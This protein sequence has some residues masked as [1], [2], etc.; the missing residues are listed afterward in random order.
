MNFILS[1]LPKRK[2]GKE[3]VERQAILLSGLWEGLRESKSYRI[4]NKDC[5]KDYGLKVEKS[6]L[7]YKTPGHSL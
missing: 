6:A 1:L 3:M 5:G 2:E 4:L 7:C